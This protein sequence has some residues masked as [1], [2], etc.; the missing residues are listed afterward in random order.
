MDIVNCNQRCKRC[1][2]VKHLDDSHKMNMCDYQC[3]LHCIDSY[4]K[5]QECNQNIEDIKKQIKKHRKENST[6]SVFGA[7]KNYV[8]PIKKYYITQAEIDDLADG[9]DPNQYNILPEILRR[10]YGQGIATK[11]IQEIRN[12]GGNNK[13]IKYLPT[14]YNNQSQ[15]LQYKVPIAKH[16]LVR[17]SSTGKFLSII[18]QDE[19]NKLGKVKTL[20]ENQL[21]YPDI[22]QTG[23]KTYCFKKCETLLKNVDKKNSWQYFQQITQ[24]AQDCQ[25]HCRKYL[26]DK[27]SKVAIDRVENKKTQLAISLQQEEARI[28]RGKM[29]AEIQLKIEAAQEQ[30]RLAKLAKQKALVLKKEREEREQETLR[31]QKLQD[32]QDAR[33]KAELQAAEEATLLAEEE[34]RL[35][36]AEANVESVQKA[37]A[38]TSIEEGF[39]TSG[40][41]WNN[42]NSNIKSSD[43][44]IIPWII[45]TIILLFLVYRQLYGVNN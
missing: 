13:G 28:A 25:F 26:Q 35:A 8:Q 36:E 20:Q 15:A 4:G 9:Y 27:Y 10:K 33:I 16:T 5:H 40:K 22:D 3:H 43:S 6:I 31:F 29:Q 45:I 24:C 18:Q 11:V 37:V 12:R 1:C 30:L 17:G 19:K 2:T 23:C 7:P 38:D 14:P 44:S 41:R 42:F 32:D 39:N 34:A 21:K